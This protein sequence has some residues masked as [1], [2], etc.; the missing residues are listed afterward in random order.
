MKKIFLILF[1]SCLICFKVEAEDISEDGNYTISLHIN[2][3]PTYTVRLPQTIDVSST[4]TVLTFYIR[5]DIY[6]DQTLNVSFA[7]NV[8]LTDSINT[9]PVYITQDKSSWS[10]SE[11]SGLYSSSTVVITH[12]QL[13]AGVWTGRLDVSISLLGV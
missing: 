12:S 5:G 7:K 1:L 8:T 10:Y 13:N 9:V 4:S 3:P 6:A 2:N 11:L